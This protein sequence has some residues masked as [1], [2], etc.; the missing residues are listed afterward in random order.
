MSTAAATTTPRFTT[1][2]LALIAS[3][4]V[5]IYVLID[6][7][8]A[9]LRPDLSL[10]HRAESDYGVGSYSW[11]MD[12]NFLIRG[13]LSLALAWALLRFAPG[14]NR[15]RTG[16][17]FLAA[18][19][20]GSGILAFF[21]DDPPGTPVTAAGQ[22]HLVVALIAF[23]CAAV[24]TIA[25]SVGSRHFD[26]L[27]SLYPVLLVVSIA[28]VL[29]LLLLGHTNF[30]PH[31]LDGLYERLFLGLELLWILIVGLRLYRTS[32]LSPGVT[33]DSP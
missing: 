30:R 20:I 4:G 16:V 29:P 5:A 11:L 2:Q 3:A 10:L 7:A 9:F 25:L 28:A 18:W 24:A 6:V 21:P 27:R 17:A 8:L 23:L 33:A 1:S 31:T 32:H 13:F 14:A 26:Q 19:A 12:I 15:L 22:V